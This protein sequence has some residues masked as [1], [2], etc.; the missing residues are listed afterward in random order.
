MSREQF[1]K[2]LVERRENCSALEGEIAVLRDEIDRNEK[3]QEKIENDAKERK[4]VRM[5]TAIKI[6]EFEK[7]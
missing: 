4:E 6:V 5:N 2:E 3:K 1:E 7:R